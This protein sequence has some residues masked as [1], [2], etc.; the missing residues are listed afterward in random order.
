[1]TDSITCPAD[2]CD[3]SGPKSSVLG[4]Y[5]G[6]QD[7]AHRGGYEHAKTLL[8]DGTS[9]PAETP[10]VTTQSTG[11]DNPVHD[12]PPRESGQQGGEN[13]DCPHCADSL[14]VTEEQARQLIDDGHDTC[15]NCGRTIA[16]E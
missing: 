13:V 1:M 3:Y 16:Y 4:H 10:S 5:S 12:H 6:K 11:G 14:G 7:E 2:G 9:Q 15:G 8:N